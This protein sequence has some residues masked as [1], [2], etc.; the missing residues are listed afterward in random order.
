M[1]AS[2][3][4]R[5]SAHSFLATLFAVIYFGPRFGIELFAATPTFDDIRRNIREYQSTIESLNVTY[6]VQRPEDWRVQDMSKKTIKEKWTWKLSGRKQLLANETSE[7]TTSQNSTR[8][9]LSYDGSIGYAVHFHNKNPSVVISIDEFPHE[10][11]TLDPGRHV[12]RAL[13]WLPVVPAATET[14]NSILQRAADPVV[15]EEAVDGLDCV[16]VNLGNVSAITTGI[17]HELVIWFSPSHG[18]LPRRIAVLPES[19]ESPNYRGVV[20][21]PPGSRPDVTDVLE[22]EQITDRLFQKPRW[23][24]K[25]IQL[26]SSFCCDV[27]VESV[28]VNEP[29]S[30]DTFIPEQPFGAEIRK[31]QNVTTSP[32]S[33][34]IGGKEGQQTNLERLYDSNLTNAGT[35]PSGSSTSRQ[36]GGRPVNASPPASVSWGLRLVVISLVFFGLAVAVWRRIR[37]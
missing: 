13:G 26:R 7:E 32:E 3:L 35:T 19:S 37:G 20:V 2:V 30:A 25:R 27:A 10:P 34:F 22:Y 16:K 29:I 4:R 14:V 31:F 36:Q 15:T 28:A 21:L 23:F 33:V 8:S 9:W 17:P 11:K 18:L 5:P 1:H 12:A 24:P 6:S